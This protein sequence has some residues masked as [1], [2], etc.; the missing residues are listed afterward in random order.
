MR[1]YS[2]EIDTDILNNRL[3]VFSE[4]KDYDSDYSR[5][6]FLLPVLAC[7]SIFDLHL[8]KRFSPINIMRI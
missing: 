2:I 1:K 5:V 6:Y 3:C 4:G 8:I 7:I